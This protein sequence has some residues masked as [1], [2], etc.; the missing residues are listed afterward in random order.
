VPVPALVAVAAKTRAA[1]GAV[2]TAGRHWR[3]V[4]AG[5]LVCA[6]VVAAP[7]G[8]V[9]I[10]VGGAPGAEATGSPG[11]PTADIPDEALA[12]YQHAADVWDIDWAIL[13]AIGKVECDHGR[14][15]LPGCIPDT[16]NRAGARGYMQF[17]GSTWRAGLGQHQLEPR[18]STPAPTG[19]GYATDGDGDGAADPWSW[20][21]AAHSAARYLA[22]NGINHN[23][24]QAVW[25][26]NHS[27]TYVARV[28]QLAATYRDT[29]SHSQPYTGSAGDVPLATVPCPAG[30]TTIVHT[31][32]APSVA[33][34]YQAAD[35]DG[36]HLCGG[37]YRDP[38]QQIALRRAH[39]G[40]SAYAVYEMPA[41]HCSP[42]TAR[43]GQ[44]MHERA[45]AIDLTCDGV[46]ITGRNMH[47]YRWVA[48]HSATYGLYELATGEEPWHWST[49]GA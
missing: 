4:V 18:T 45:L 46:L 39:C 27:N 24:Q 32:I 19:S 37:G 22:A 2:R 34:M 49:S 38:E 40:T 44:S 21:D 3:L 13:A 5:T 8:I 10:A 15:R 6:A 25:Q 30:G 14:S 16:I 28:L 7:V 47:C 1:A 33:A 20:P 42:P 9:L 23:P 12:A 29:A 36:I 48:T 26:Y 35:A 41:S 43:P 31:V 11:A 17:I